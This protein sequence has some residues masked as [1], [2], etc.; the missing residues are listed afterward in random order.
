[1][2]QDQ[3]MQHF[4]QI[5]IILEA[6]QALSIIL[7]HNFYKKIDHINVRYEG[8]LLR[9]PSFLNQDMKNSKNL[10]SR[11]A[12][13]SLIIIA[14]SL[15]MKSWLNN[16]DMLQYIY[17]IKFTFGV[18]AFSTLQKSIAA[19]TL[20]FQAKHFS[21]KKSMVGEIAFSK[22][23]LLKQSSFTFFLFALAVGFFA[24]ITKSPYFMGGATIF[25][26]FVARDFWGYKK[27]IKK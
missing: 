15:F 14:V 23:Y 3:I 17:L 4:V 9:D 13:T 2:Q 22:M 25:L 18:I 11:L 6:I 8:H 27:L 10:Y 26:V 24:Y 1:M 21:E 16:T 12:F 5:I 19:L 7:L 20:W